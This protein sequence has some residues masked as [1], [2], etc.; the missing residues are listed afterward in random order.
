[1]VDMLEP[2]HVIEEV[3]RRR[4]TASRPK[5]PRSHAS[6]SVS[7]ALRAPLRLSHA[8]RLHA[9]PPQCADHGQLA[10]RSGAVLVA[11]AAK[12]ATV[13]GHHSRRRRALG[14][15]AEHETTPSISQ[16]AA[17]PLDTYACSLAG[18]GV[19]SLQSATAPPSSGARADARA[20]S[21][22]VAAVAQHQLYYIYKAL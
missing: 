3:S 14:E 11:A 9:L 7:V 21:R 16:L 6:D 10:G 15:L 5:V 4:P 8:L 2:V 19:G 22:R 20:A 12:V 18:C 17:D 13:C 1:M